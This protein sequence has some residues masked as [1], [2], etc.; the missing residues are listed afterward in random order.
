M[1]TPERL[2]RYYKYRADSQAAL[3]EITSEG[4]AAR[5]VYKTHTGEMNMMLGPHDLAIV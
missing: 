2:E 3:D 5:N 4:Y 1:D